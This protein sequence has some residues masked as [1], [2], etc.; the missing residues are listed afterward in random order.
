MVPFIL[1]FNAKG[2]AGGKPKQVGSYGV[3]RNSKGDILYL[4][5]KHIGVKDS[6]E[7]EVLAILEAVSMFSRFFGILL[8]KVVLLTLFLGPPLQLKV[9]VGFITLS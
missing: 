9:L 2:V 6:N 4:F 8:W 1:K 7:A 5:S 3:L